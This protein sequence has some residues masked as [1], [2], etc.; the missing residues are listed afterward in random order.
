M[1]AVIAVDVGGTK[2]RAGSVI[3]GILGHV[4]TVPTPALEGRTAIL[5]RI[6]E[7]ATAVMSNA[8]GGTGDT[9]TARG[10]SSARWR[11]GIG[12]AGVIDPG[13]GTVVSATDSLT[14]WA[15]TRLRAEL[16]NR[17]GLETRIVNDVHAHALGEALSGA[18]RGTRSSLLVAA[19]TGIGGGFISENAL[20]AGRR[21]AAGHIGHVP[22]AA[23]AGLSCP[24]GATGHVEAIASGPAILAAYRRAGR[25]YGAGENRS[26]GNV[27]ATCDD[28][29]IGPATTRELLISA[30]AGD[31]AA[32]EAFATAARALGSALGGV[33]NVLS[34]EVIVIGGGLAGAGELWWSPLREAFAVEL[35]PAVSGLELREAE[36]GDDAALIGAAGLWAEAIRSSGR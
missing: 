2:I 4:R 17:L 35:I 30:E 7:A 12:A 29:E 3:D 19:G 22:I 24:C 26:A 16:H 9:P 14:G 32:A 31:A 25:S 10:G 28:G 21:F 18:A 13:T 15:G 6:A 11:L 20:L 27:D 23:A 8:D 5:D 34:P 36:L 1:S 33:A